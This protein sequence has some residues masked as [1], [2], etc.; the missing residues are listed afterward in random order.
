MVSSILLLFIL[1][2]IG[3]GAMIRAQHRLNAALE[4]ASR[5]VA[6]GRQLRDADATEGSLL[7]LE[8]ITLKELEAEDLAI[9]SPD[10][11]LQLRRSRFDVSS[12]DGRVLRATEMEFRKCGAYLDAGVSA[13]LEQA[14]TLQAN[15]N[16]IPSPYAVPYFAMDEAEAGRHFEASADLFGIS[17]AIR[18]HGGAYQMISS[19]FGYTPVVRGEA[20]FSWR[21]ANA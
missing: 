16:S 2:A 5:S 3:V 14:M 10:F 12:S 18:L 4:R 9:H 20:I 7:T 21:G 1:G 8:Q 13:G 17:A 15:I 19:L 11:I 6:S